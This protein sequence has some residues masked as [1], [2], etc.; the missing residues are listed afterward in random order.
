M[1]ECEL[2]NFISQFWIIKSI[3][4]SLFWSGTS[5]E[6]FN[7]YQSFLDCIKYLSHDLLL[8]NNFGYLPSLKLSTN[9][10]ILSKFAFATSSLIIQTL[11]T[12]N[13]LLDLSNLSV[14]LSVKIINF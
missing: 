4:F 7:K 8:P 11:S 9:Q 10:S 3:G 6:V 1:Y 12:I 5:Q 13:S 14:N 2:P